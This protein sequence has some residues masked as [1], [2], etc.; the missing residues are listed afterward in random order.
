MGDQTVS[1]M[2]S[3]KEIVKQ[4]ATLEVRKKADGEK[5]KIKKEADAAAERFLAEARKKYE[6]ALE[7]AT[8][9]IAIFALITVIWRII[10]IIQALKSE[11]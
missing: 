11:S 5:K 6:E 1:K 8:I 9:L 4:K 2:E 7:I 3:V 10:Y